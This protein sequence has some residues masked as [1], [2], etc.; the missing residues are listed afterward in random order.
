MT[1]VSLYHFGKP[2]KK[3]YGYELLFS[4][5]VIFSCHTKVWIFYRNL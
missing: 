4:E 1:S 3:F 2:K 5:K